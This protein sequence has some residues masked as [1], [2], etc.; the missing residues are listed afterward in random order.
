MGARRPGGTDVFGWWLRVASAV[1][2]RLAEA[3]ALPGVAAGLRPCLAAG[4][5]PV[6]VTQ[7]GVVDRVW[8]L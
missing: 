6:L 5:A 3:E 4:A 7:G 1:S 8:H 2:H